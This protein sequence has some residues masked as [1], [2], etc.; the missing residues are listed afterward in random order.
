MVDA[1]KLVH[2]CVPRPAAREFEQ[3]EGIKEKRKADTF[4]LTCV[5]VLC[6]TVRR[7]RQVRCVCVW[8][9]EGIFT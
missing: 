7:E 2:A 3:P 9:G 5:S 8:E 4:N 6:E 1:A